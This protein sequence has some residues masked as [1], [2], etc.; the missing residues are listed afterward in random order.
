MKRRRKEKAY[1][2]S[3]IFLFHSQYTHELSQPF[4]DYETIQPHVVQ[5]EKQD[6]KSA[7]LDTVVSNS[8]GPTAANVFLCIIFY[9]SP[10]NRDVYVKN[11]CLTVSSPK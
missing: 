11:I 6:H 4:M 10:K 9:K 2:A 3:I 5:V 7:D 8:D 1:R